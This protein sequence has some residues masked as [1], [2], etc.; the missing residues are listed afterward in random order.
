MEKDLFDWCG[1]DDLDTAH[2][3]FYGCTLKQPIFPAKKGALIPCISIDFETGNLQMLEKN[4][5]LIAEHKVRMVL[6]DS[7]G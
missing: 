7:E 4:G 1:W 6:D 5:T 3:Q 2:F